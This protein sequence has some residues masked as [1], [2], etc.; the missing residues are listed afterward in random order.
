MTVSVE[1]AI[2]IAVRTITYP[3]GVFISGQIQ[4]LDKAEVLAVEE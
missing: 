2:E 1:N 4:I 3:D